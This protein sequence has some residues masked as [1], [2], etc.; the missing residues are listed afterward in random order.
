MTLHKQLMDQS[1]DNTL[2]VIWGAF[3]VVGW[4]VVIWMGWS[5]KTF[6]NNYIDGHPTIVLIKHDVETDHAAVLAAQQGVTNITET[7]KRVESS[8]SE[9]RINLNKRLDEQY[10]ATMHVSDRLDAH[11]NASHSSSGSLLQKTQ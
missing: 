11:M 7:L 10:A 2:G 4:L 5:L 8:M 1:K 9:F 3:K 6:A